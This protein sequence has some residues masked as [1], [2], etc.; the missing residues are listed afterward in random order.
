MLVHSLPLMAKIDCNV[1][2]LL[3]DVIY[4]SAT[5]TDLCDVISLLCDV[6]YTSATHTDLVYDTIHTHVGFH[7]RF[8]RIN[9]TS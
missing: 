2:S 8:G 5:H 6:I 3:C 7:F 4:T 9:L 1:I